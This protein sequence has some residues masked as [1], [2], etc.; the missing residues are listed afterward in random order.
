MEIA[1]NLKYIFIRC[2]IYFLTETQSDKILLKLVH[3]QK[4]VS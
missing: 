1:Q 3:K 4:E 2:F